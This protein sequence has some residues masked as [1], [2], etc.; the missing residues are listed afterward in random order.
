MSRAS[1]PP[2]TAGK[3]QIF[4]LNVEIL[5]GFSLSW[6]IHVPPSGRSKV[7]SSSHI[8]RLNLRIEW[9]LLCMSIRRQQVLCV[10]PI[11]LSLKITSR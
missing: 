5:K 9:N 1:T 3:Y 8:G 7:S 11:Q 6:F 10:L 2:P 4:P